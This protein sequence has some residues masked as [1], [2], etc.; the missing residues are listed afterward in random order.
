MARLIEKTPCE[1]LLPVTCGALTLRELVGD[2]VTSVA[3]L[4]GQKTK[5]AAALKKLGLAWP[6]PNRVIAKD[7]ASIT[8]TGRDQAFLIGADPDTL[9]GLAALTDQTDGWARIRLEGPG[10]ADVLARLVPLDLRAFAPG[11]AARSQLGHMMMILISPAPGIFDIMV[12]RSMA[13][14]AVHELHHA[15]KALAARA[16]V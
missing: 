2:R 6:E 8:W 7:R 12:F 14:T 1:A 16:A 13:A 10:A 11:Q 15:M 9:A 5:L 4:R 3:P